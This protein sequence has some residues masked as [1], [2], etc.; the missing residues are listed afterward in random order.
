MQKKE[1]YIQK[2][3]NLQRLSDFDQS[4]WIGITF[5]PYAARDF[6]FIIQPQHYQHLYTKI[7]DLLN[8]KWKDH[9]S[10]LFEF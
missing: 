5:H 3:I 6:I 2:F 9:F 7:D 1:I 4:K 10:L 8:T